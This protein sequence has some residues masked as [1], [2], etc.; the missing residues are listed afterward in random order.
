MVEST[1]PAPEARHFYETGP[2]HPEQPTLLGF[3][4]YLMSDCLLFAILFACYGV[5]GR[6]YAGGPTGKEIFELPPVAMNTALLLF[7]SITYGMAMIAVQNNRVKET[8]GWLAVTGLLGC[9]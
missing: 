6:S 3:W 5:L 8:L 2:H 7:S 4:L 9:G 1:P